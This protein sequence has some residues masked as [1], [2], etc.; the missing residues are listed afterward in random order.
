[1]RALDPRDREG[2]MLRWRQL[3]L[4]RCSSMRMRR[5][6]AAENR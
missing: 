5:R 3:G 2:V 1:M 6:D 4:Y